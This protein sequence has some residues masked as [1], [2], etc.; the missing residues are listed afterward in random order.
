[1]MII[2]QLLCIGALGVVGACAVTVTS[3]SVATSQARL[4]GVQATGAGSQA[5]YVQSESVMAGAYYGVVNSDHWYDEVY[6]ALAY[7]DFTDVPSGCV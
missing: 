6:L 5:S 3:E 4:L 7:N 2:R 1:M